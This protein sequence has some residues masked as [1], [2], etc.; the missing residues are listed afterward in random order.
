MRA[1]VVLEVVG[2]YSAPEVRG[3]ELQFL[4]QQQQL[5]I[6]SEEGGPAAAG[7]PAETAGGRELPAHWEAVR[8]Y[9]EAAPFNLLETVLERL[10]SVQ[11]AVQHRKQDIFAEA[12]LHERLRAERPEEL[13]RGQADPLRGL[14]EVICVFHV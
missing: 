4:H 14:E 9:L 7:V 12:L 2:R 6:V 5:N 13:Q 11:T 3:F 10:F 8:A 1:A